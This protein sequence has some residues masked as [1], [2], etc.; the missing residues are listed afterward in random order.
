[1]ILGD[2]Q[3]HSIITSHFS[4][5]G[6]S[7]FGVI[8]K[9]IWSKKIASDE[10][11]RVSLVTRSMLLIKGDKV[12]LVDTGNGDKWDQ[13]MKSI[14]NIK[15]KD[16]N[17]ICA[18]K[19]YSISRVDVT[20]VIC[21]HLHFDHSG[22]NTRLEGNEIVPMFPNATYHV[23]RDN[24]IWANSPTEKDQGSYRKENWEVI[25][26]NGMLNI[27]KGKNPL[28][29]DIEL[30]LTYGHT[31]GQIHPLI[32]IDN[33]TIFFGGDLIPTKHHFHLPCIMAYDNE[34]I[35]SLKEKKKIF[36]EASEKGWIIVLPHDPK[37]EAVRINS[38]GKKINIKE[39]IIID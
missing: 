26:E 5:D 23:H 35:K 36:S 18:L 11:N 37:T 33:K 10:N 22:G 32:S 24:W 19:K 21:T 13:K 20:D 15:P 29:D 31:P 9:N 1:L 3:I 30:I 8:P 4:L 14:L 28:F 16:K 27:L 17:M 39:E 12:I 2:Y 38:D 6:G 34:P 7:M 25:D